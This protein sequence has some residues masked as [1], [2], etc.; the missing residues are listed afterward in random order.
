MVN[1]PTVSMW[2]NWFMSQWDI[3]IA[4]SPEAAQS[5]KLASRLSFKLADEKSYSLFREFM[6]IIDVM[7]L[8][9]STLQFEPR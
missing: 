1:P 5:I 8:S 7:T 6:Q 4:T 3:F 2:S 9:A